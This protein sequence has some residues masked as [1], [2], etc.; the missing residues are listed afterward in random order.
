MNPHRDPA[1]AKEYNKRTILGRMAEVNEYNAAI[2]F[3]ASNKA[4]SYMTGSTLVIDGGW[5]AK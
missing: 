4:S 1:F 2:L 5:T 3:L